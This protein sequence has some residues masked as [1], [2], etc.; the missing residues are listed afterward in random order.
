MGTLT[1]CVQATDATLKPTFR[2][3]APGDR[4]LPVAEP[5]DALG[6]PTSICRDSNVVLSAGVSAPAQHG[7]LPASMISRAA[8][9]QINRQRQVPY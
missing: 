5:S 9:S 8:Q 1:I 2:L 4:R 7:A 6:C 3:L